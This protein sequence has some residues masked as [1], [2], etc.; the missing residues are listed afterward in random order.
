MYFIKWNKLS[1]FLPLGFNG[2][3]IFILLSLHIYRDMYSK[4]MIFPLY[5]FW[6]TLNF[7]LG[8]KLYEFDGETYNLETIT[9]Y[10]LEH[11]VSKFF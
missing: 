8:D 3:Q 1:I 4:N 6:D 11:L 5:I 10:E 7:L 9:L 2:Y